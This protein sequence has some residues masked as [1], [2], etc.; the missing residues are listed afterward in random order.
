MKGG[1]PADVTSAMSESTCWRLLGLLFERPRPGWRGEI[2]LLAREVSDPKLLPKVAL[3]TLLSASLSKLPPRFW[4]GSP[5]KIAAATRPASSC[6]MFRKIAVY[7]PTCS[8]PRA[9]GRSL[10]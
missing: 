8:C 1:G 2:E 10:R 3:K 5:V 4:A 9:K 6:S 7:Q